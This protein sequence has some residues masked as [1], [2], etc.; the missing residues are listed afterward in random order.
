MLGLLAHAL[1]WSIV[2]VGVTGAGYLLLPRVRF[3]ALVRRPGRLPPRSLPEHQERVAQL[4]AAAES[5]RLGQVLT[6][7]HQAP[8][9]PA[10]L[11]RGSWS[12]LRAVVVTSSVSA[13]VIHAAV[14]PHHLQERAVVGV[15]FAVT[16]VAQIAWAVLVT[17]SA[18]N[19][20]LYAG[21]AGSVLLIG[22]WALARTVG[23]PAGLAD[24]HDGVGP[25]D[26]TAKAW[27]LVVLAGC[28]ALLRRPP[29][30][31]LT[32]LASVGRRAWLFAAASTVTLTLITL[33][34][35]HE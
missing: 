1:H 30:D 14:F 22:L 6:A 2:L 35:P 8:E 28:L 23:L 17:R 25:W 3:P 18:S 21:A 9:R 10:P 31:R 5:G 4:R 32:P 24:G 12:D 19:R 16:A 11:R 33:L 15:F 34:V 13:G 7:P 27:E 26:L 29:G 20:L